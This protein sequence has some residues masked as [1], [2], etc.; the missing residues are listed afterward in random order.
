M[1]GLA[2]LFSRVRD[3]SMKSR[4][5][6]SLSLLRHRGPDG[7]G[8][9][10]FD[11]AEGRLCLGHRRLAI[12]DLS[13][14]G[15]QPMTSAC[16]RYWIV[17]NGEIYNYRELRKKIDACKGPLKTD[18][19]TEV[20]LEL[21]AQMGASVLPHLRGMFSFVIFDKI[22]NSL[23]CFRDA[24]GI[25][26]FFFY[27]DE[28]H[29]AFASEV[30]ALRALT[31]VKH[32]LNYQ[33]AFDYLSLG[34]YNEVG[35]TFL[36]G[37]VQLEPGTFFTVDLATKIEIQPR[38]WWNPAIAEKGALGFRE[39]T[40]IVR[41]EFLENVR[42]HLRSD[43]PLGAALSGGVDS[44]CLVGAMR[45]LEPDMDIHTFSYIANEGNINE[46]AW[47]NKVNE[48]TNAIAHKVQIAEN[49]LWEDLD[50][51]IIAQGEPFGSTS[52]YGSYRVF[53]MAHANGIT[54]CLEGQ[55]ADEMFAGYEGYP[56]MRLR[57][58]LE[59]GQIPD[60]FEFLH[61]WANWPGRSRKDVLMRLCAEFLPQKTH[62]FFRGISGL[63]VV[64]PWL[65]PSVLE[66][67][68]VQMEAYR[69]G[70]RDK[71]AKGR[72][73]VEFERFL[74]GYGSLARLLR[75]GDRNSMRWSIENRVPFLTTQ[76]AELA[77]TLPENY[78]V[79]QSGESKSVFRAAMRGLVPDEILDRRDKV[80]FETPQSRWL[81]SG[82]V[83]VSSLLDAAAEIEFFEIDA[84][85]KELA[86]VTSGT[87]AFS[88]DAWRIINYCK[89]AAL[90]GLDDP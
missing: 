5:E 55:G 46:E 22:E 4:L 82:R 10:F 62:S 44:S 72:R 8:S 70:H 27:Y 31:P 51:M 39:A 79:S 67:S 75:H 64:K 50:D 71:H 43:V 83:D 60:A 59:T 63:R 81:G 26:P 65:T 23:H 85:R 18:T 29:F 6:R 28:N 2:G 1:C 47:V 9:Q 14:Q 40:E 66:R 52:I 87:K 74:L 13:E 21:Y 77:L 78:L 30:R 11:L 58:L 57:S 15:L 36:D 73:L 49:D 84:L 20:L 19:D 41:E 34:R 76:F 32:G 61:H 17:F 56:H 45:H 37:I 12:I 24:F 48:H 69:A 38:R 53:K 68:A 33:R 90:V 88:N 54:V 42:L 7:E 16:G 25:K 86:D 80:G 89:W 3:D 35:P